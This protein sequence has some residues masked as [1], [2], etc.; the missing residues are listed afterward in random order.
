MFTVRTS[1]VLLSALMGL[2][3][4]AAEIHFN[5]NITN[6]QEPGNVIP[7]LSDGTTLRPVSFGTAS[8]VLNDAQTALS[9]TATIFNID[10]TGNQTPDTN[11]NLSAAHIHSGLNF[12]P[13]NNSVA[14]GFF[15]SPF[16][17]NNPMDG[18]MTPFASGVGGTFTGTWDL[19]EGNN[20]TLALQLP[21]I[22]AGRAYINFH[23]VQFPGGE[24]R[25]AILAANTPDTGATMVLL[26][27]AVLG[28]FA[29]RRRWQK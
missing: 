29:I 6:D 25:G 28:L 7:T 4:T 20:T 13:A 26:A 21:N 2:S 3:A 8:F 15:G 5:A 1:C 22:F 16:N 11:D 9:F 24:I 19:A 12:P 18:G 23:T 27:G 10:V 17:N 14:W